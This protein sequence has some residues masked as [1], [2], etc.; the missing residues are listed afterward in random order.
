M[1]SSGPAASFASAGIASTHAPETRWATGSHRRCHV[2]SVRSTQ[3]RAVQPCT[4]RLPAGSEVAGSSHISARC[5]ASVTALSWS[6]ANPMPVPPL[7][8]S[9]WR[10]I[11]LARS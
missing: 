2:G 6:G 7:P 10:A 1:D 9:C 4:V 8:A 3:S 5:T 11:C